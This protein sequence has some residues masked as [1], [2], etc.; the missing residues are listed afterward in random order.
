M[1]L[2]KRG[3]GNAETKQE[4]VTLAALPGFRVDDIPP[5]GNLVLSRYMDVFVLNVCLPVTTR[6]DL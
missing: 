2:R 6:I 4:E 1:Q 5:K 3:H